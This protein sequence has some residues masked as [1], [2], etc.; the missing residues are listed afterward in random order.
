MK[1]VKNTTLHTL[2]SLYIYI[3]AISNIF[4]QNQRNTQKNKLF[5]EKTTKNIVYGVFLILYVAIKGD[6]YI[7]T[8][9]MYVVTR[10]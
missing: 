1:V 3:Q 8:K 4:L 5:Q 10:F 6:V 7:T 9:L 2:Y